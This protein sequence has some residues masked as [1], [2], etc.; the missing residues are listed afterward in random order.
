ML[1]SMA[2]CQLWKADMPRWLMKARSIYCVVTIAF[3]LFLAWY[4]TI[5]TEDTD[6]YWVA[7]VSPTDK[8]ITN[9]KLS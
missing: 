2:F 5:R 9:L 3:A 8:V 7:H 1:A 6:Q 4:S